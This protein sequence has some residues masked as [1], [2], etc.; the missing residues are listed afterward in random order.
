MLLSRWT[1]QEKI[2]VSAPYGGHHMVG[3]QALIGY[4]VNPLAV[5]VDVVSGDPLFGEV[6]GRAHV[7]THAGGV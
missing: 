6:L 1:W 2:C 3:M 4:F 7:A 5:L